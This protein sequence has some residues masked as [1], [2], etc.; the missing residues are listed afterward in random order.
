ME[1]FFSNFDIKNVLVENYCFLLGVL[2]PLNDF[3]D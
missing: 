2:Q 3:K 1:L